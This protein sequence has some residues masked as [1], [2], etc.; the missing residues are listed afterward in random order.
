MISRLFSGVTRKEGEGLLNSLRPALPAAMRKPG[1]SLA[2]DPDPGATL[3]HLVRTVS[4]RRAA[5]ERP[6]E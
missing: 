2:S 1:Y 4:R 3:G 6:N 5:A